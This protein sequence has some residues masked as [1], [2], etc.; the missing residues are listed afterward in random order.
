ME[1]APC[2][3]FEYVSPTCCQML[4]QLVVP[5]HL[6]MEDWDG[7]LPNALPTDAAPKGLQVSQVSCSIAA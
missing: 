3:V 2:N 1:A 7:R 6:G 4:E 5:Y